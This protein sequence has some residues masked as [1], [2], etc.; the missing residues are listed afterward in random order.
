MECE[1]QS[2]NRSL[3]PWNSATN[4]PGAALSVKRALDTKIILP[5]HKLL[6]FGAGNLRNIMQ[7]ISEL[8]NNLNCY[9]IEKEEVKDRFKTK[10]TEYSQR[11]GTV[12]SDCENEEFDGI[13]CTFVLETICPSSE[14]TKTLKSLKTSLGKDGYII[15]SFRGYSGVKGTK[16]MKCPADEGFISPLGTFI[17]P[18]SIPE[19]TTLFSGIGFSNLMFLEKY[20]VEY[21][22]NIHVLAKV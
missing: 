12:L 6:E 7:I 14:R 3:K 2:C 13:I 22:Q 1:Y 8:H 9:V 15:A 4:F 5:E 18:Y 20:R 16:Y 21:P 17:K 19:V 11:K 10:Y